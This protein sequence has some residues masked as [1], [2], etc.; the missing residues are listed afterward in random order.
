M[1]IYIADSDE[2]MKQGDTLHRFN[3]SLAINASS[4]QIFPQR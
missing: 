2:A 1:N 4:L 3:F